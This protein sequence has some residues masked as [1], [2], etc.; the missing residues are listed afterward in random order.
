MTLQKQN[1]RES[2]TGNDP[3]KEEYVTAERFYTPKQEGSKGT[4]QD[5]DRSQDSITVSIDI[6]SDA[7]VLEMMY[8]VADAQ[9]RARTRSLNQKLARSRMR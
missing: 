5:P 7:R 6:G 1:Y 3:T 9:R 2:S 4:I 8:D